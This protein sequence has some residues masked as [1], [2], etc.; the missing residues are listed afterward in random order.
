MTRAAIWLWK[1]GLL[2]TFATGLLALLPIV[3]TI[4]MMVWAGNLL[5]GWLGTESLVGGA[6]RQL[7]LRFVTDPTVASVVAWTGVLLAIWLLGALLKS[8]GKQKVESTLNAAM[9]RIPL[10]NALYRP[11]AQV[12]AM[13]QRDPANDL[14]GMEVVYC[15]FGE[16]GSA[17]FL[18]LLVDH[19]VYRFNGRQ[20]Q[21]VYVPTAPVPMTG[22]VIFAAV[23]SVHRVD[24]QVDELLKIRFSIGVMSSRVIP[25]QY[26]VSPQGAQTANGH[27]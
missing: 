18:G 3:I 2:S 5:R 16:H 13:F 19:R 23:E 8:I 20:C 21:V 15:S 25:S 4:G 12:V 17:G 7:G 24:M 27:L 10:V 1:T 6:L 9:D 26:V 11:V 14:H 22:A